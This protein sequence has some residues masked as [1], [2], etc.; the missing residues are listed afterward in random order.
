MTVKFNGRNL[1]EGTILLA[2]LKYP[3]S[4][5]VYSYVFLKA[6]GYWYG[7]G[8]APQAAG[9]PVIERWLERD[10]RQVVWIKAATEDT[11]AVLWTAEPEPVLDPVQESLKADLE[12][13]VDEALGH[14]R[15]IVSGLYD[16]NRD[17][18]E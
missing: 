1:P 7:T 4:P 8:Q 16:D 13:Q 6:G 2:G 15:P 14:G 11:L 3:R 9:W 18:E 10:D 12:H 5:K 17:G